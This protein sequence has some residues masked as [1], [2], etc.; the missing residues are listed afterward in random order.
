MKNK[1][2]ENKKSILIGTELN[3]CKTLRR[4]LLFYDGFID[5]VHGQSFPE[6]L[7]ET[8]ETL[9]SAGLDTKDPYF[10]SLH[11]Y[12]E[13]CTIGLAKSCLDVGLS[14]LES[15]FELALSSA[16]NELL[17]PNALLQEDLSEEDKL[18]CIKY[19]KIRNE[20][21][22]NT[23]QQLS[24]E[25]TTAV[26]QFLEPDNSVKVTDKRAEIFRIVLNKFPFPH[27]SIPIQDILEFKESKESIRRLGSLRVFINRLVSSNTNVNDATQEIEQLLLEA[28]SAMQAHKFI[29]KESKFMLVGRIAEDAV[30]FKLGSLLDRR[31]REKTNHNLHEELNMSFNDTKLFNNEL[32]SEWKHIAYILQANDLS[33]PRA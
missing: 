17:R 1:F 14:S 24:N 31:N 6:V 25:N 10:N 22:Y 13:L 23:T 8:I 33:T 15:Q 27:P 2:F 9:K 30:K 26:P 12:S 5:G 28:K 32:A 19:Q 20:M 11:D 21:I 4:D 29:Y 18:E 7:T 3:H 16:R